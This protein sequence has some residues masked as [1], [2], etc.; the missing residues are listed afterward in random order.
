M[1]E[2]KEQNHNTVQTQKNT[3]L[4]MYADIVAEYNL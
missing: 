3:A 2:K 4:V 1:Q